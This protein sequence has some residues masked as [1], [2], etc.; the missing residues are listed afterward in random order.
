MLSIKLN[1]TKTRKKSHSLSEIDKSLVRM[2]ARIRP[3]E[4]TKKD[5]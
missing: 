5:S 2:G 4:C 3:V 1:Q